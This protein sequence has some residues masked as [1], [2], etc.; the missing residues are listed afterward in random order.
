[1]LSTFRDGTLRTL[2]DKC[3]IAIPGYQTIQ[4]KILPEI[5]DSKSAKYADEP[6]IGRSTPLKSYAY[7][8]N[9]VLSM[10]LQFQSITKSEL[11][12]NIKH[13]YALSSLTYPRKST[14]NGP[15]APPPICQFNCGSLFG[16]KPLCV[17]MDNYSLSIP[18]DVV[19]DDEIL[20]PYYFVINTSWHVVYS[21]RSLPNQEDILSTGGLSAGGL[22]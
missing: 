2:N 6:I 15:Y 10:K 7:S 18:T 3:N 8:D 14:A 5:T 21:S 9:R 16:T 4:L 20:V 11:T 13:F 17:I 12:E 22:Q 19:W 1:M